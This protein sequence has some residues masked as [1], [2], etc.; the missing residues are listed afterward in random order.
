[1]TKR[2]RERTSERPHF[3]T[4]YCFG[5][6]LRKNAEDAATNSRTGVELGGC[7]TFNSCAQL[8]EPSFPIY[9]MASRSA[10]KLIDCRGAYM[11][12]DILNAVKH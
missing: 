10:N 7:D 11:A 3:V 4:P 5:N 6:I 9:L 1:M 2:V 8:T 12:F